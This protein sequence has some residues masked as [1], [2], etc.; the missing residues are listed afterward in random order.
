MPAWPWSAQRKVTRPAAGVPPTT[1]TNPFMPVEDAGGDAAQGALRE[2]GSRGGDLGEGAAAGGGNPNPPD[3]RL[4]ANFAAASSFGSA[5]PQTVAL[6]STGPAA[7]PAV[8]LTKVIDPNAPKV[9]SG[10]APQWVLPPG[11]GAQVA[12]GQANPAATAAPAQLASDATAGT[13]PPIRPPQWAL[14]PGFGQYQSDLAGGS[15]GKLRLP[16]PVTAEPAAGTDAASKAA[17]DAYRDK[18]A[19]IANQPEGIPDWE[20]MAGLAGENVDRQMRAAIDGLINRTAGSGSLGGALAAGVGNIA[21]FAAQEKNQALQDWRLKHEDLR[22]GDQDRALDALDT[23]FGNLFDLF[24]DGRDYARA[25][26]ESDRAHARENFESDRAYEQAK[27]EW[28]EGKRQWQQNFD[29]AV[30]A[31]MA[32]EERANKDPL[33]EIET[34]LAAARKRYKAAFDADPAGADLAGLL[35]EIE[36]WETARQRAIAHTSVKDET[37]NDDAAAAANEDIAGGDEGKGDDKGDDKGDELPPSASPAQRNSVNDIIDD[38]MGGGDNFTESQRR[39]IAD[40]V[41]TGDPATVQDALK[42][43]LRALYKSSGLA[44]YDGWERAMQSDFAK[45]LQAFADA[46]LISGGEGSRSDIKLVT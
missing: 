44:D 16:E 13:A 8:Q 9:D 46:G 43:A 35:A 19:E 18:A 28:E 45:L 1:R 2:P 22:R 25:T 33:D 36:M 29:Q 24:R 38:A 23:S 31:W 3:F 7:T 40:A 42:T 37:A 34:E 5:G 20:Q 32:N 15:G 14:P 4:P 10:Q 17:A 41:A 11:F 12:P 27:R 21:A 39:A 30:K 6:K 26:F